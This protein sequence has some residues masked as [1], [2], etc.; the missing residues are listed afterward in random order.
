M[1]HVA[2]MNSNDDEPDFDELLDEQDKDRTRII[3]RSETRR[4]TKPTT[5]IKGLSNEKGE[6]ERVAR[7]LKKSLATG[8]SAKDGLIILQ[9]D[10]REGVKEMLVKLGYS[11]TNIDVE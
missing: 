6:L 1:S 11:S 8:G 2:R 9:G 4:F 5:I 3:I 10:H 7:E